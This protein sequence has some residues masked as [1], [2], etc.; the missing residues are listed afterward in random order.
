MSSADGGTSRDSADGA[1]L[2]PAVRGTSLEDYYRSDDEEA[3][4][5]DNHVPRKKVKGH[6]FRPSYV[7]I[8]AFVMLCV[9]LI[10]Y[11]IFAAYGEVGTF[12]ATHDEVPQELGMT[13]AYVSIEAGMLLALFGGVA[14]VNPGWHISLGAFTAFGIAHLVFGIYLVQ[15]WFD[16]GNMTTAKM[17][18]FFGAWCIEVG[19]GAIPLMHLLIGFATAIERFLPI[20][21][22]YAGAVNL[23]ALGSANFLLCILVLNGT[24]LC[25]SEPNTP[26]A[27]CSEVERMAW[28]MM[29]ASLAMVLYGACWIRRTCQRSDEEDDRDGDGLLEGQ[30]SEEED[31]MLNEA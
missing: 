11:G 21:L 19:A 30:S 27:G 24:L 8:S 20:W 23:V 9:F 4:A 5:F 22:D 12:S 28:A 7:F 1:P 26:E 17:Q 25:T 29:L 18:W 16:M 14:L 2:V 31:T 6:W 10:V 13:M 3:E 15:G